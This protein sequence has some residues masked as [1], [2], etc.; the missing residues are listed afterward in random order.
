MAPPPDEEEG[1]NLRTLLLD[2]THSD[3]DAK[4][5]GPL[6]RVSSDE[7]GAHC[8]QEEKED[9][10]LRS[11]LLALALPLYAPMLLLFTAWG[12]VTPVL[13]LFALS[14]G[15][16]ERTVGLIT[17]CR[18]LGSLLSILPSGALI[19]RGGAR[20][21]VLS[22]ATVYTLACLWGAASDNLL[23]L[24]ASRVLAGMGYSLYSCAQQVYVRYTVPSQFRGRVLASVG[25]TYRLGGLVAP[26]FG[27]VVA[28]QLGFRAVFLLQT[29]ISALA[30][31]FI[32]FK[33][34]GSTAAASAGQDTQARRVPLGDG[35]EQPSLRSFFVERKMEVGSA[36]MATILMSMLRSV[37]DLLI[38]LAASAAGFSRSRVGFVTAASYAGDTLLFPVGGWLMDNVGLWAAGASSSAIMACG[39]LVLSTGPTSAT[40]IWLASIFTG[41][42]NGLSS[43]IVMALGSNIAPEDSRAGPVIASYNFIAALGGVIGPAVVGAVAGGYGLGVGAGLATVWACMSALWWGFLLP[44]PALKGREAGWQPRGEGPMPAA[45]P[46]PGDGGQDTEPPVE[47]G[48]RASS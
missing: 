16:S 4:A 8:H 41:V 46:Q 29:A 30:L 34:R 32:A 33:M 44:R 22:G 31:P 25:G 36:W 37:R 43:G 14:L 10:T 38:P 23:H 13:P 40:R 15:A 21:A 5:A 39:M 26:L 24:G 42:G 47:S 35:E 3:D 2:A 18:P 1:S 6:A 20:S 17:S 9:V 45:E 48:V 7:R 28:Q 11:T 19:A 12:L 27:G